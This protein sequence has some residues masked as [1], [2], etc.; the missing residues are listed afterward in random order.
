VASEIV[1]VTDDAQ[2]RLCML[3]RFIELAHCCRDVH[4]TCTRMY[5]VYVGLN[6]WAVQ[7]LKGL[8]EKLPTKWEKRCAEL[9]KSNSAAVALPLRCEHEVGVAGV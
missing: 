5:A 9:D 3:K 7:R 4:R 1:R 8:W 6:Q 2:M